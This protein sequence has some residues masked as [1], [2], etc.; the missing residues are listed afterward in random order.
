MKR[1]IFDSAINQIKKKVMNDHNN[2]KSRHADTVIR[3][4]VIYAMGASFVPILVVDIFAVS[5]M[6]LDMIRQ[7]TRVYNV[8]YHETQG[9]AIVTALT[10]ST[11]ARLG[12]RSLLKLIPGVGSVIGGIT[13]SAFAGA[14][15]YALGEVF[16]KHFESGG[17]IL[18]F[19]PERLKNLYK[20]KFEKGK[21]MAEEI[22]KEE[23][24]KDEF[25]G[26]GFNTKGEKAAEEKVKVEVNVEEEEKDVLT[27]LKE[28]GDLKES[29]VITDEE[30]EQMKKKLIDDF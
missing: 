13:V 5:A 27:R 29:G 30:F 22:R 24:A 7:L 1:K 9:K 3:N 4:H 25:A 14:S 6:Q 2:D 11:I 28:L 16:K 19:D 26:T 17:T 18:D 12:A 23:E 15:T 21:K 10:S 8:D 20:E